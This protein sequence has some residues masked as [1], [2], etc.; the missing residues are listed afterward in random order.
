M[1]GAKNDAKR[2]LERALEVDA[3]RPSAE[4]A[5]WQIDRGRAASAHMGSDIA[6]NMSYDELLRQYELEVSR[7][8]LTGVA[9]NNLALAYANRGQKLDRAL[10]LA[11]HAVN[12]VPNRPEPMD[13]LGVVLLKMRQYSA[14]SQAFERAL[15]MKPQGE[16]QRQIMLHLADSYEASGLTDKAATL[17]NSAKRM[18]G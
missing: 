3:K 6:S 9:S 5:L 4:L 16:A 11:V 18:H 14:A 7:G 15:A 17:R 2:A 12:R 1:V 10:E 13:T 8:D